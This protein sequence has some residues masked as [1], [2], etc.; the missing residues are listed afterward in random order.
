MTRRQRHGLTALGIGLG[1]AVAVPAG[2]YVRT[3]TTVKR[4]PMYWPTH[5]PLVV[6]HAGA[7][8]APLT[9]ESF[10]AIV[11]ASADA[12]STPQVNC[13]A[14]D[15]G[16]VASDQASGP[17]QREK[18]GVNRLTFRADAWCRVPRDV[19]EPCYDPSA[20]AITSVWAFDDRSDAPGRIEDADIEINA[21]D[22][23]WDDLVKRGAATSRAQD[24]QNTLTHEFGH[25]IGLDHTCYVADPTKPRPVDH[26]GNPV[27]DCGISAPQLIRETT[28]YASVVRGDTTRRTLEPDDVQAV[29]E[30]YPSGSQ[31][32]TNAGGS[33]GGCAVG[34][35][36]SSRSALASLLLVLGW[37]GIRGARR[38]SAG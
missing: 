19:D 38:R 37:L 29:C 5:T 30:V 12:W 17:A 27:P 25:F 11:Q 28:M 2:A 21:V 7:P 24:L 34:G 15:I 35:A 1:L 23:E 4:A 3:V 9:R 36:R 16:L 8:P 13:T 6:V 33:D 10:I 20:L 18:P 26:R 32:N 31:P 22:F 14:M